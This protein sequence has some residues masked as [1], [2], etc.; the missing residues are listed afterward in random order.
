VT[1]D[2]Q[3]AGINEQDKVQF[4]L[5]GRTVT[6]QILKRR[7]NAAN[8]QTDFWCEELTGKDS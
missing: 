6:A 8:V 2:V 5:F 3:A 1:D 4:K 7:D